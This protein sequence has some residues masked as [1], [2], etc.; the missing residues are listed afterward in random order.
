MSFII[1][2][3]EKKQWKSTLKPYVPFKKD[4]LDPFSKTDT[5]C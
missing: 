4:G 3:S 1:S 5:E 2:R